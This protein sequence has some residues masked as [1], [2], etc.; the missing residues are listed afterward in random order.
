MTTVSTQHPPHSGHVVIHFGQD[1]RTSEARPIQSGRN[2]IATGG[3]VGFDAEG[4]TVPF[5]GELTQPLAATPLEAGAVLRG[6]YVLQQAIGLGGDSLVFRARDLHRTLAGETSE[7]AVALK[8]LRPERRF[9]P[10][11]LERLKRS[12]MQMQRLT[13]PRI[14]RVFD[15]DSD[16]AVWFMSMEVISGRDMKAWAREAMSLAQRLKVLGACCEAVEYAHSMGIVHGDLK[17]SNVL[18]T[19]DGDVKLIDFGSART[20]NGDGAYRTDLS[21]AATVA[22]ASPQV[23]AGSNVEPC[24]DI[25]SLACLSY[26]ILSN[27]CHPFGGKSPLEAWHTR[28]CPVPT[29]DIPSRLFEVLAWGLSLERE[30]RPHSAREFLKE[31]MGHGLRRRVIFGYASSPPVTDLLN[32]IEAPKALLTRSRAAGTLARYRSTT[33]VRFAWIKSLLQPWKFASF[34]TAERTAFRAAENVAASAPNNAP[35]K[36]SRTRSFLM[37]FGKGMPRI[38][39]L[40]LPARPSDAWRSECNTLQMA[41]VMV[42]VGLVGFSLSGRAARENSFPTVKLPPTTSSAPTR[43]LPPTASQPALYKTPSPVVA[44]VLATAPPEP[45][46]VP[47]PKPVFHAP[48]TVEFESATLTAGAGQSLIAIPV[49]R[50]RSTQGSASVAWVIEGGTAQ[51]GVDY[52]VIDSKVIRFFAGQTVRDLFI[53]LINSKT[54]AVPRGPL[55]FT[56][57]LRKLANGPALGQVS[58]VT[59]TIAPVQILGDARPAGQYR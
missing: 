24:D 23:L 44:S 48:G 36:A 21:A 34:A 46:V 10:L 16:N 52:K 40:A 57:E 33:V 19:G 11:A 37:R 35:Q 29:P 50:L 20:P 58:R 42:I 1:V 25:F 9:D 31:L 14:A 27:G 56:V 5:D 32:G 22:Y 39:F 26:G 4:F 17:P 49:R 12:F 55:T 53:Q 38:S 15:L 54:T 28:M 3:P 7:G 6:R 59:V 41:L 45:E 47:G 43:S 13:N 2:G 8:V 51:P 18:V 30:Q